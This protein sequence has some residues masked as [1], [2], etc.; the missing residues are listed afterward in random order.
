MARLSHITIPGLPHH[1]TQRGARR[2]ALFVEAG[3]LCALSRFASRGAAAPMR[4]PAGAYC[5]TP[6]HVQ[7]ILVPSSPCRRAYGARSAKRISA[8][9]HF[10][11]PAPAPPV[12]FFRTFRL[13]RHGPCP[14]CLN[15]VRHLALSPHSRRI[16]GIRPRGW[17]HSSV[18]ASFCGPRRRACQRRADPCDR[19]ALRGASRRFERRRVQRK[20]SPRPTPAAAARRAGFP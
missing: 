14:H 15:A 6:N 10:S 12:R 20:S 18:A 16:G 2:R 13:R 9:P 5:L 8:T 3:R 4:S 19:A 7:L 17:P 11:T 1:V